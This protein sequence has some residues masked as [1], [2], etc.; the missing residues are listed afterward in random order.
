MLSIY[1]LIPIVFLIVL[2]IGLKKPA[3]IVAPLTL[4]ITSLLAYF[5]W[6]QNVNLMA[7]S[8]L[9]GVIYG[10]WPI[11]IIILG[12]IT[13]SNLMIESGAVKDIQSLIGTISS[14]ARITVVLV[15]WGLESF[16]ES[17]AGFGSGLALPISI[18]TVMGVSPLKAGVVALLANSV[19]TA[20]G[21]VGIGIVAL[22]NASG[23]PLDEIM[24]FISWQ[25]FLPSLIVPFVI[26][27]VIAGSW[28]KVRE[29]FWV[30]LFAG[31]GQAV[32][33]ALPFDASLVAIL[34]GAFNIG[35][36]ILAT[37]IF[38]PHLKIKQTVDVKKAI[39]TLTPFLI[40]IGLILI[41]GPL[42]P[43]INQ[44]V[45]SFKTE[46][47]IYPGATKPLVIRWIADAGV[48]LLLSGFIG[49]L[50]QGLSLKK[51]GTTFVKTLVQLQKT[52]IV[53]VSI[54]AMSK[55]MTHSG[56]I[57]SLSRGFTQYL[58]SLY[59]LFAPVLGTIGVL[60][61]GSVASSGILMGALQ[62]EMGRALDISPAWLVA[63]NA[64]GS[65]AGKMLAPHSVAIVMA[66]I[67]SSDEEANITSI[68]FKFLLGYVAVLMIISMLG[69]LLGI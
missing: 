23:I 41:T 4:L 28:Q 18:L 1:A 58:G 53:L 27:R 15:A 36:G 7:L 20:Y 48:L 56:M 61:T 42:F 38:Y 26:T 17:I 40:A 8:A 11:G 63:M 60:V 31:L 45:S 47:F 14:D 29:V 49:A 24:R 6:K 3:F 10:L 34:S 64:S 5:L 46:L 2:L 62:A 33:M 35:G 25:L 13:L 66:A 54:L 39:I 30:P 22:A 9:E 57:D 67:G 44:W 55:I 21:G 51:I 12:S 43:G 50:I 37:N 68:I 69:Y 59:P 19:P 52:I 32:G 65:T 16:L